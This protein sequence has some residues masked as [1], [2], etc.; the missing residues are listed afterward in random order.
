MF[1]N[2]MFRLLAANSFVTSL[3]RSNSQYYNKTCHIAHLCYRQSRNGS[4]Y[5][6]SFKKFFFR[7][8]LCLKTN[9]RHLSCNYQFVDYEKSA[10]LITLSG[11]LSFLFGK[12]EDKESE[13][14]MTIKRGILSIQVGVEII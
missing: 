8:N 2:R 13:L 10:K 7:N 14:I 12:E 6:E 5:S 4:S 9:S 1:G 3:T 11:L